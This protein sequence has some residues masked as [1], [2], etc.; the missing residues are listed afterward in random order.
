MIKFLQDKIFISQIF[1]PLQ[2]FEFKRSGISIISYL[3][4]HSFKKNK[5]LMMFI[6]W[7]VITNT[8]IDNHKWHYKLIPIIT[9]IFWNSNMFMIFMIKN[10]NNKEINKI[11][12]FL[13]LPLLL[14]T[15]I[16]N[17]LWTMLIKILKAKR[18]FIHYRWFIRKANNK[19]LLK[20]IRKFIIR[21]MVYM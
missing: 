12:K 21:L 13:H 4:I 18:V 6:L 5:Q 7:K 2:K 16:I 20:M 19:K 15:F 11:I 1:T 9:M 17:F 8:V 14:L 3:K 10:I